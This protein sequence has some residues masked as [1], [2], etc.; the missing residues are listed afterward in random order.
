EGIKVVIVEGKAVLGDDTTPA[1]AKAIAMNN[2]RR[3]ALEEAVGVNLHSSTLVYNSQLIS[4][5][6]HTAA[7]GLI[8]GQKVIE[9]RC[10][11]EAG[12]IYCI[13]KIEAQVKPL[14][15]EKGKKI[16]I[17]KALVQRPDSNSASNNPVFQDGDE[18]QI[19]VTANEDSFMNI[20]SVDQYGNIIKLFP[21][22]YIKAEI[23]P[24]K[25]EF[26]F[27]DNNIRER[28]LKFRVATPKNLSKAI[29]SVLI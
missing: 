17:V 2:A 13:A 19:K 22:D 6:I 4:D 1:Q 24:S 5:L 16:G 15:L 25:K 28:G 27:P 9:D 12:N 23:L 18:I 8:V 7:K 14:T 10:Y 11:T 29:E 20:F 3:N 21:N 26:V